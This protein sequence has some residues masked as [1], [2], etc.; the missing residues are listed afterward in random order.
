MGRDAFSTMPQLLGDDCPGCSVG[1]AIHESAAADG[2]IRARQ[3]SVARSQLHRFPG[4]QPE[5]ELQ[6]QLQRHSRI[7]L[8]NL[9]DFRSDIDAPR[10]PEGSPGGKPDLGKEG[11]KCRSTAGRNCKA[12]EL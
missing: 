11:G 10:G 2:R 8:A 5:G 4:S 6:L 7:L 1:I 12:G 3:L 9:F